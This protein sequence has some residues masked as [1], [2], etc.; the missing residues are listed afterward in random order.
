MKKFVGFEINTTS[1][2][3]GECV[4][5]DT[6]IGV[7]PASISPDVILSR[8][9]YK[10]GDPF[11]S[12]KINESYASLNELGCFSSVVINTDKKLYNKVIPKID[13]E[14]SS[15]LNR[16]TLSLGYDTEVGWRVKGEYNR[17]NFFG[18]ARKLGVSAE[19]SRDLKRFQTT[20]F[21]PALLNF[22]GRY[23]D[24]KAKGGYKDENFDSYEE[25]KGYFDVKLSH[26][27]GEFSFD[28]GVG[29]ENIDIYRQSDD[30]RILEGNFA[31]TYPYFSL[32]YD[33]RDSKLDPKNGIYLSSYLEYGLPIDSDSSNYYKWILEG[34]AIKT[35]NQFTI[36]SGWKGWSNR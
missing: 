17:F 25:H 13:T 11:T 22:S 35:I 1:K 7:I 16:T 8:V 15:K 32:V 21:N 23:F 26:T 3:G 20:F 10:K 30:T 29:V 5:G 6:E 14:L 19:Y 27:S 24:L 9:R 28:F 4:F 33:N 31:L 36:C 34:R 12:E 2:K 18:N